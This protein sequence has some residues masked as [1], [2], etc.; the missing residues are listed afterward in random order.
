MGRGKHASSQN[1]VIFLGEA[2]PLIQ[3]QWIQP[4][5]NLKEWRTQASLEPSPTWNVPHKY[6]KVD[7]N[8]MTCSSSYGDQ[9]GHC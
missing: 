1:D 3:L 2:L 6:I 9:D 4:D 8:T 7:K 5:G